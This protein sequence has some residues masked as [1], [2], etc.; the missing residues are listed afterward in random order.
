MPELATSVISAIK[1]HGDVALGNILGSSLFNLLGIL[2]AVVLV[3]PAPIPNVIA[4]LAKS[5]A[6]YINIS[7]FWKIN[8]TTSINF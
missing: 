2:G 1:R 6:S 4:H 7:Y 5:H 8:F 3:H